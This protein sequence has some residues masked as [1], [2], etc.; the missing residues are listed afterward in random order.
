M[1]PGQPFSRPSGSEAGALEVEVTDEM[2]DWEVSE[3]E[4]FFGSGGQT[5]PERSSG[6]STGS[7]TSSSTSSSASTSS[8][9]NSSAAARTVA[10]SAVIAHI[11]MLEKVLKIELYNIFYD[12][13]VY[14]D[15][16]TIFAF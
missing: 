7:G 3:L 15:Q 8:G 4:A 2:L 14:S 6:T 5:W 10:Q 9:T 1:A 11:H 12:Q 13:I 16:P